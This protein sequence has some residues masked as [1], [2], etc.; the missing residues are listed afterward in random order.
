MGLSLK[1]NSPLHY[2]KRSANSCKYHVLFLFTA[3]LSDSPT[4]RL[5]F[6]GNS[7]LKILSCQV[8][9]DIKT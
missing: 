4:V 8:I 9:Q 6:F 2:K 7:F 3:P 5:F 1:D